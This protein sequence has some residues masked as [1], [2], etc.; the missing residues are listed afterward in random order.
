MKIIDDISALANQLLRST[1]D[2]K[3]R[4][5]QKLKLKA[6]LSKLSTI[7]SSLVSLNSRYVKVIHKLEQKV[8]Q[9]EK[10]IADPRMNHSQELEK[11]SNEYE[12]KLQAMALQ[13]EQDLDNIVKTKAN[14]NDK[15]IDIV[16]YNDAESTPPVRHYILDTSVIIQSRHIIE[17]LLIFKENNTYIPVSV[18][19]ELDGL[20]DSST[21]E[22]ADIAREASAYIYTYAQ[23]GR[24]ET[25]RHVPSTK[26]KKTNLYICDRYEL[27][28]E[29]NSQ[30]DNKI[31]GTAIWLQM[32][33]SGKTRFSDRHNF[34]INHLRWRIGVGD[35]LILLTNDTNMRLAAGNHNI[36]AK[37][38]EKR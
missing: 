36:V 8:T 23:T 34:I 26:I 4:A 5:K 12:N 27:V 19:K 20:K 21:Q 35:K 25:D 9:L 32:A 17:Q 15:I 14:P 3:L 11:I 6:L 7:Y 38:W 24:V 2:Q 10:R 16:P 37:V 33:L 22:I 1:Q 13:H 30:A 31:L 28:D 29:L 18:L